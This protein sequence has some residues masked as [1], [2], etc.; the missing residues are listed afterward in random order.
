MKENPRE[1]SQDQKELINALENKKIVNEPN[2]KTIETSDRFVQWFQ[3]HPCISD[4]LETANKEIKL[5][6]ANSKNEEEIFDCMYLRGLKLDSQ[7]NFRINE[8]LHIH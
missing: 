3:H 6:F 2:M 7:V 5:W 4:N 8:I 1:K